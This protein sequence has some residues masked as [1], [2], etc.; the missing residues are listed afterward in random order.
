MEKRDVSAGAGDEDRPFAGFQFFRVETSVNVS[1]FFVK[2]TAE[3]DGWVNAIQSLVGSAKKDWSAAQGYTN[4]TSRKIGATASKAGTSK[5]LRNSMSFQSTPNLDADLYE[6]DTL[7][8]LYDNKAGELAQPS[9]RN[10][11][12]GKSPS[13]KKMQEEAKEI[14]FRRVGKKKVL[15]GKRLSFLTGGDYEHEPPLKLSSNLL[16]LVM[17]L[18]PDSPTKHYSA[19]VDAL[20]FLK[21]ANAVE[22]PE[23]ERMA[24]FLNV[25]HTLLIHALLV[26]GPPQ[27]DLRRWNSFFNRI[28]YDIGGHILSL[29]EIEHCI[30]RAKGSKPKL[31]AMMMPKWSSSDPRKQF[32]LTAVD[33]RVDVLLNYGSLS[34]P[35][36]IAKFTTGDVEEQLNKAVAQVLDWSVRVTVSRKQISLSKMMY[37]YQWDFGSSEQDL[38]RWILKH[39]SE[40]LSSKLLALDSTGRFKDSKGMVKYRVYQYSFRSTFERVQPT[41][42][43]GIGGDGDGD[44]DEN[45]RDGVDSPDHPLSSSPERLGYP[46]QEDKDSGE[47]SPSESVDVRQI[48]KQRPLARSLSTGSFN[49]MDAG[50]NSSSASSSSAS[51]SKET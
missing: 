13:A 16:T 7:K 26:L 50:P 38:I 1:Y 47:G 51:K 18:S 32:A 33:A 9:K 28:A 39:A 31:L 15:N 23:I 40:D 45:R 44:E 25:F 20:N 30:L 5:G 10:V 11:K 12:K 19:F 24:F 22:L 49:I 34:C 48:V 6:S 27:A 8:N 17:S 42:S 4:V 46:I 41:N 35:P 36:F 29:A 14:H 2:T 3:R 37:W 21:V 43:G